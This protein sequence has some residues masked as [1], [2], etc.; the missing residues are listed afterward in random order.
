MAGECAFIFVLFLVS[1]AGCFLVPD[2]KTSVH[3]PVGEI[4][5]L[6][7]NLRIKGTQRVVRKFLG[8]PYAEPPTGTRR[9]RKPVS[10]AVF[11]SS[12]DASNYGDS[13]FQF[14][15]KRAASG[16]ISY[17]EDCLNLNIFVPE[18]Q[19]SGTLQP[20]M[21]WIHGG[22]FTYGSSYGFDGGSFSVSGDVLLVTVNYRL[23]VFGFLSTRDPNCSG[24]FG[25]WDE[26]LAIKWVKDNIRAFGGD[27]TKITVFG[28]SSGAAAVIYQTI[29]QGNKGLFQRAIAQSGSAACSWAFTSPQQAQNQTLKFAMA[30]GCQGFDSAD[31]IACLQT[32]S[33]TEIRNIMNVDA[34]T[35][36]IWTPVIDGQFILETP[37]ATMTDHYPSKSIQDTFLGIDLIIGVNSKEGFAHHYTEIS[38]PNFTISDIDNIL[39]PK[40]LSEYM[41]ED[42]PNSVKDATLLEYKDWNNQRNKDRQ[43]ARFIDLYSDNQFNV[44][45]ALT[46]QKHSNGSNATTFVYELST[47][48]PFHLI[49]VYPNLDGPTVANHADDIAFI[50]GP[51]F[52]DTIEIPSGI[53]ATINVEHRNI[54]KAM[55][56]MWTN[57]AKSG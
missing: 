14:E 3:T 26:Q 27:P 55:S 51:W 37:L 16:N 52:E 25:L 41:K 45:A 23:N 54:G 35:F 7:T 39:I 18:P 12:F 9:F 22:G 19:V 13:C 42:V 6:S 34:T 48:P 1:F 36:G 38:T 32:K 8:I 15:G 44:G 30:A 43:L 31:I 5:G 24:N 10:K 33:S 29:Y 40:L 47:A 17:S 46:A 50:F 21:I 4:V 2:G 56:T 28:E 11:N 20:V 49:P 53:T 57:F